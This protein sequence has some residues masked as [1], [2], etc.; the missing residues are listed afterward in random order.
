MT[1]LETTLCILVGVMA[2][3]G[4]VCLILLFFAVGKLGEHDGDQHSRDGEAD[5]L[6]AVVGDGADRFHTDPN[7]N[8]GGRNLG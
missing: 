4:L 3:A 7:T 8:T 2:W 1:A 5:G 6:G